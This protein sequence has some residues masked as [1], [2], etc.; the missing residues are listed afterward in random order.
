[1]NKPDLDC[2]KAP[3]LRTGKKPGSQLELSLGCI[4]YS[5]LGSGKGQHHP[6]LICSNPI[7]TPAWPDP[8]FF[9]HG[10]KTAHGSLAGLVHPGP[11]A[12]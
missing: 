6:V 8:Q 11:P 7:A 5:P 10:R 2:S 1:M 3:A 12:A 9:T 4:S